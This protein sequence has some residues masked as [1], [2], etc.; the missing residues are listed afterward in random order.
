MVHL[1]AL[2]NIPSLGDLEYG[3]RELFV[4]MEKVFFEEFLASY[5]DH[6]ESVWTSSEILVY[7][8]GGNP[9]LTQIFVCWLFHYFENS[10][11]RDGGI[12]DEFVWPVETIKLERHDVQG[13]SVSVEV[14]EC[15]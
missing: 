12:E 15:M 7:I 9:R 8:L 13:Q 5:S 1:K 2:K 6:I 4:K 10:G 11:V 14:D 3:G